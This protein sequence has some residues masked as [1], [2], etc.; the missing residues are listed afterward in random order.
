MNSKIW[1]GKKAKQKV[2]L[3]RNRQIV[4]MKMHKRKEEEVK[5]MGSKIRKQRKENLQKILLDII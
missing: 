1:K 2:R 4:H 5:P 3:K